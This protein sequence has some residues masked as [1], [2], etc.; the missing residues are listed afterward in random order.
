MP[1]TDTIPVSASIASTGKGIRYV[2]NWAYAYSGKITVADSEVTLLE[3]D[4]QTGLVKMRWEWN[5]TS[6]SD[7]ISTDDFTFRCYL[8]DLLITAVVS[9]VSDRFNEATK[10][11]MFLVPPLTAVKITAENMNTSSNNYCYSSITGR[12]YGEA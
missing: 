10:Y 1:E 5:Y 8:N 12:V 11:K 6:T 2:E 9:S 4:T 7:T 3:F